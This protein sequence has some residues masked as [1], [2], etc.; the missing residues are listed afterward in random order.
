VPRGGHLFHHFLFAYCSDEDRR[1]L[2]K[3]LTRRA[4]IDIPIDY[5]DFEPLLLRYKNRFYIHLLMVLNGNAVKWQRYYLSFLLEF[6]GA[7]RSGLGVLSAL[8]LG[9]PLR[10]YDGYRKS[11]VDKVT[12]E[13]R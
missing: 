7:S 10:T 1:L 2:K 3:L 6:K 4:R 8:N 5:E 13:L 12:N 11:D 9:N